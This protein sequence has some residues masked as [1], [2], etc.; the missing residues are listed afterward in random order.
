VSEE[1]EE[2]LLEKYP[3]IPEDNVELVEDKKKKGAGAGGWWMNNRDIGFRYG[4][5]GIWVKKEMGSDPN[6]R[7]NGHLK[8]GFCC[9]YIVPFSWVQFR[10]G[11]YSHKQNN[12]TNLNTKRLSH[13]TSIH[14]L[15][16]GQIN[17]SSSKPSPQH[18]LPQP[19][20]A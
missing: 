19:E 10:S 7:T 18:P 9:I 14:P 15:P 12:K 11:I 13:K 2:F 16:K 20:Q 3:V 5:E 6:E 8:M 1:I 17:S 4:G